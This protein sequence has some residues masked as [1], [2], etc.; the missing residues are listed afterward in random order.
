MTFQHSPAG[1]QRMT[2]DQDDLCPRQSG[3]D[4]STVKIILERLVDEAA[5][6]RHRSPRGRSGERRGRI[7]GVA[8][9]LE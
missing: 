9:C 7:V 5:L 3:M 1:I 6:T 4:D 8:E 2:P